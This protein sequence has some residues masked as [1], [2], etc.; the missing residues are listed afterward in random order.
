[1]NNNEVGPCE[2][3]KIEQIDECKLEKL[4][5]EIASSINRLS[6]E[7]YVNMPDFLIGDY[8]AQ[9]FKNLHLQVKRNEEWRS[10]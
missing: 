5:I 10:K 1:M 2:P 9:C 8:L 3:K 7:N 6:M 4:S